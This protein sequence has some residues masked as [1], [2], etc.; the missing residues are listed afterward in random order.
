MDDTKALYDQ[1]VG[2]LHS[3]LME[4]EE[5]AQILEDMANGDITDEEAMTK[6]V[7]WVHNN[8]DAAAALEKQG[9]QAFGPYR[10]EDKSAL[11]S[12][13]VTLPDLADLWEVRDDKLPRLNP[14]FEAAL[15]ERLQFDGDVPELR[16]GPTPV[17]ATPAISVDSD[18]R[19]PVAL[20]K[21]LQGAS[22]QVGEEVEAA[23][24]KLSA[25]MQ[26]ALG[27]SG[28]SQD[29]EG[30]A[31]VPAGDHALTLLGD[32]ELDPESYKRGTIPKALTVESPEGQS[33]ATLTL[34]EKKEAAWLAIS[35]TQGRRSIQPTLEVLVQ[36]ALA[37]KGIKTEIRKFDPARKLEVAAHEE[38]SVILEGPKAT[39]PGFAVVDVAATVLAKSLAKQLGETKDEYI[40]EFVSINTVGLRSVGWAA[41][42]V[43]K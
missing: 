12:S 20:G 34:E 32:A 37:E 29:A 27:E 3:S 8:P 21:M 23:R 5:A 9:D 35:T 15:T 18:A 6:L 19:D 14:L 17:G 7:Q 22:E 28:L 40:L 42:C 1:I 33:L 41:R 10:G 30:N 26:K 43:V 16:T 36:K 2:M 13:N 25:K 31:L 39:Q 4:N 11:V 38:W 24:L